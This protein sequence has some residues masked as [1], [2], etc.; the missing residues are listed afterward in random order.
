MNTIKRTKKYLKASSYIFSSSYV[1]LD[2]ETTG[3]DP[4]N[5]E[6]IEIGAI[7]VKDGEII[8]K[9]SSLVKP[10]NRISD[11]ITN[12]TGI[13]NEIVKD[14]NPIE[15]VIDDF[16]KFV[17]DSLIIG[18]NVGF[19]LDFLY[20]ALE[21]I[22]IS[23][24][25]LYTDTLQLSLILIPSL[26]HHRLIDLVNYYEIKNEFGFHRALGD[27]INTFQVYEKEKE[28]ILKQYGS[29]ENFIKEP[30][31]N[32]DKK[33]TLPKHAISSNVKLVSNLKMRED[34]INGNINYFTNKGG[35]NIQDKEYTY[36]KVTL[37]SLLHAYSQ[38]NFTTVYEKP[39]KEKKEIKSFLKNNNSILPNR[40]DESSKMYITFS[41]MELEDYLELKKKNID[42]CLSKDVIEFIKNNSKE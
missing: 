32:I 20:H 6:I 25:Y 5:D 14:K 2:L 30:F 38:D 28:E 12:L 19:D 31:S 17:D 18:Q 37:D 10:K 34:I 16:L 35:L 22:N 27:C 4:E 40:R 3:L 26:N 29:F 39:F 21:K 7:K 36:D 42:V 11:F 13:N 8:D 41:P 9:F 1:S 23:K 33:G 15:I 24:D